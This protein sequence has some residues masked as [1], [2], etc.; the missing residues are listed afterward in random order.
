MKGFVAVDDAGGQ[1]KNKAGEIINVEKGVK[2]WDAD[3]ASLYVEGIVNGKKKKVLKYGWET[4]VSTLPEAAP[5]E[6]E[7]ELYNRKSKENEELIVKA[8]E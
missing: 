2:V 7:A 3:P 4:V 5:V 6:S 8:D 1:Y